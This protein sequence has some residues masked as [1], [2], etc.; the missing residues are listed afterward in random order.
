MPD[1]P[2][3]KRATASGR[4][5]D[6]IR[7]NIV[8]YVALFFAMGL[9]T[10]WASHESIF[11]NDIVDGEVKNPDLG[12]N[13]V[14]TGKVLDSTLTG[15]DIAL[16][17]IGALDISPGTFREEDIRS[18]FTGFTKQYAIPPNA[19]QTDEISTGTVTR[20]DLA[21]QAE[22]PAGFSAFDADTGTICNA[23]C[24]EGTLASLPAGPYLILGQIE[25]FQQDFGEALMHVNCELSSNGA[26]SFAT[27]R[28]T[29]DTSGSPGATAVATLTMQGVRTIPA[30]GSVSLN[31]EDQDLGD[32]NG[33]NLRITAIALGTLSNVGI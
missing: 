25:V 32:V 15:A 28:L 20:S 21:A 8:G 16:N 4:M 7:G 30:A 14:R 29:G 10:A 31:C 19:I 12:A 23:G 27:A 2:S 22:A 18:Q 5:R 6:H 13:A 1:T 9:G 11:S 24:T 26:F 3:S 17:G 33:G